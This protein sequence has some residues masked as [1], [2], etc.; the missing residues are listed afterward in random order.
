VPG[1]RGRRNLRQARETR[2]AQNLS[3]MG[4]VGDHIVERKILSAAGHEQEA[5]WASYLGTTIAMRE[6]VVRQGI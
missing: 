1:L 5:V 2:L 4:R 3:D 6:P